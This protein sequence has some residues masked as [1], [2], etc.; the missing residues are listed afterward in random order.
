MQ[1]KMDVAKSQLSQLVEAAQRG[2]D[3][4]LARATRP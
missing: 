1:V 3:V 2:E 4:I